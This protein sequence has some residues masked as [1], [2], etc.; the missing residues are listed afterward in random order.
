MGYQLV[1]HLES[2]QYN[3]KLFYLDQGAE[4]L[5]PITNFTDIQPGSEARSL[6]TG[7][8]WILNTHFKWVY[9]KESGCDICESSSRA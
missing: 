2:Q 5:P 6:T 7:E 9:I 4:D 8:K 1:K 3:R